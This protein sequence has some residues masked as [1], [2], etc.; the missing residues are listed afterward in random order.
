LLRGVFYVTT[1]NNDMFRP[2]YRPSSGCTFSYFKANYK[3]YNDFYF[4]QKISCTS[5]TSA[6][7]ITTGAVERRHYRQPVHCDTT[8]NQ[9]CQ[10]GIYPF[11]HH[12]L[13]SPSPEVI[14]PTF[15]IPYIFYLRITF[16][17]TAVVVILNADFIDLH[18][19]LLTK[20]KKSLCIV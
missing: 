12:N 16:N 7:K 6:F 5:V 10:T 14:P 2:L 9:F 4:F 17:S 15:Y 8:E 20:T 3:I 19:I 1:L 18:E 13:P 11:W